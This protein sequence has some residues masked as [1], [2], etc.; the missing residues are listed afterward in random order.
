MK[1]MNLKWIGP[2]QRESKNRIKIIVATSFYATPFLPYTCKLAA[3]E[4]ADENTHIHA[5]I[6]A[7]YYTLYK[8]LQ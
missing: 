4:R 6:L 7:N 8:I 2:F 5:R 1:N 3:K